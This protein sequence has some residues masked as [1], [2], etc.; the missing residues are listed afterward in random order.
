METPREL[1]TLGDVVGVRATKRIKETLVGPWTAAR[2]RDD[3][4]AVVRADQLVEKRAFFSLS[5]STLNVL[6]RFFFFFFF[7]SN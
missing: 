4:T 2:G 5:F 1:Y 7:F 6:V 3:E